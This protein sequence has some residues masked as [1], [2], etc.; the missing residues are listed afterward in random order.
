MKKMLFAASEYGSFNMVY[1]IMKACSGR[2]EVGYMGLGPVSD[3]GLI[4]KESM[5]GIKKINNE[6]LKNFDIFVTGSSA[7]SGLEYALWGK[8]RD[9]GKRS[10][11][12]LDQHKQ[13]KERF[14]RNGKRI[15]P[16]TI[17]VMNEDARKSL[18]K[19]GVDKD[20]IIVTGSPY[21]ADIAGYKIGMLQRRTLRK[22][23]LIGNKKVVT[24]C[25]EYMVKAGQ[26][27]EHG[28]DEHA[29]LDD[30]LNC[31]SSLSRYDFKLCIRL[32]PN[33]K[34]KFYKKYAGK[35]FGNTEVIIAEDDPE[36]RLLQVSDVVIGMS[37]I[38][39]VAASM[40]GLPIISY[41]PAKDKKKI[42]KYNEII[43]RNLVT[44]R[45]ALGRAISDRLLKKTGRAKL[46]SGALYNPIDKIL[47][48]KENRKHA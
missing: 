19:W 24:F 40:L 4:T 26:K 35:T 44:G 30:I 3:K 21:L 16:D 46:K 9:M 6:Q 10:I 34:E 37:S 5:N 14:T 31:L 28:Y 18:L 7:L 22:K 41:Q 42:F 48:I 20:R 29:L 23:L 12:I 27:S 36:Y 17:C 39:L 11:C 43:G 33:D 47:S 15:L 45:R 1:R 38:I 32:H 8:A 2:Y 13:L 25:T